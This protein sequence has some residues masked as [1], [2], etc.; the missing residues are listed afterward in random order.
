MAYDNDTAI[1]ASLRGRR[2]NGAHFKSSDFRGV[3]KNGKKFQV[4]LAEE[5]VH[6]G[7]WQEQE[8]RGGLRDAADGSKS[9]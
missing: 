3:C 4:R 7:K 5:D 2:L 9:V 1:R 8:V 6:N